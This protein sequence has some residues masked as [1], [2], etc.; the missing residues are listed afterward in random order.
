MGP[1]GRRA[2]PPGFRRALRA[3]VE[4]VAY[5]VGSDAVLQGQHGVHAPLHVLAG[6]QLLFPLLLADPGGRHVL[7]HKYGGY[8]DLR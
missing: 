4:E 7:N 1:G 2:V 3:R 6:R 8:I 5:P